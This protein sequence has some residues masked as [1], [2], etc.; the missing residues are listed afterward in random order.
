M[1][2]FKNKGLIPLEAFTTFG[3]NSKPNSVNPIGY[4]GT[5]L[6]YALAV[7]IAMGGKFRL[8]RGK[9][10][11]EFYPKDMDFR[12]KDFTTI[13]MK[14]RKSINTRWSYTGLPFTTELGK[15]WKPWMVIRELES[16]TRDENGESFLV[17][18][19][20]GVILHTGQYDELQHVED[21]HTLIVVDCL[22]LNAAYQ[23][24]EKIFLTTN[25]HIN[26]K[27]PEPILSTPKLE[28]YDRPSKY[29]YYRGL[30][31]TDLNKESLFTYNMLDGFKLTEDRT[32]AQSWL[33]NM[34][35]MQ[36]ITACDV[37]E[38]HDRVLSSGDTSFESGLEFDQ[39]WNSPGA[40]W[41]ANI[42]R[43]IQGGY[44]LLGRAR[45]YY[46]DMHR[47]PS[48]SDIFS[49]ELTRLQIE[50]IITSVSDEDVSDYLI[51][52]LEDGPD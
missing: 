13:R 12:G 43:R 3:V 41:L 29:I 10:E 27:H 44:P 14:R 31:V 40:K 5:G 15:N 47:E 37:D 22:E 9:E 38:I 33:T 19:D 45:S 24:I 39:T 11:Y 26:Q 21:N 7:T 1:I 30:R 36:T 51:G 8:Y 35:I 23:E 49:V 20:D 16:N 50:E 46:N 32:D 17:S 34:T 2:I 18:D 6:K 4:F 25:S 52:I 28:I 42:S 48:P